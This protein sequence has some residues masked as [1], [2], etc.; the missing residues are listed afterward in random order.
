MA[1]Q[2]D[3]LEEKESQCFLEREVELP[4]RKRKSGRHCKQEPLLLG[5]EG[6]LGFGQ[7]EREGHRWHRDQ[8]GQKPDNQRD[9]EEFPK[10]ELE[11]GHN[12]NGKAAKSCKQE[13]V[14]ADLISFAPFK[15]SC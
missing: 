15:I 12:W 3:E 7:I 6:W 1:T 11:G 10:W 13:K 14:E 5:C 4:P 8:N 9:L 2:C